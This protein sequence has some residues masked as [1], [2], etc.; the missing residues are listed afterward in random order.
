MVHKLTQN[1]W[2]IKQ[3]TLILQQEVCVKL[4]IKKIKNI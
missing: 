2:L 3:W 4:Q 1:C